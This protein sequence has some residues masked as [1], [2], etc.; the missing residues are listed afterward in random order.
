MRLYNKIRLDKTICKSFPFNSLS[1]KTHAM[2]SSPA[3]NF[4][5]ALD[6]FPLYSFRELDLNQLHHEQWIECMTQEEKDSSKT[7]SEPEK[8]SEPEHPE[9]DE[10]NNPAKYDPNRN[11]DGTFKEGHTAGWKKGQSGNPSGRP[12]NGEQHVGQVPDINRITDLLRFMASKPC[13]VAGYKKMTWSQAVAKKMY[14]FIVKEG[15]YQ[16]CNDLLDRVDG[17]VKQLHEVDAT[18]RTV[19]KFEV[20]KP[21]NKK[22]HEEN[23]ANGKLNGLTKA[24]DE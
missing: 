4:F 6:N 17:T 8:F 13:T 15:K 2:D 1:S 23:K 12:K 24:G 3:R 16:L 14:E 21:P 7:N 5:F 10:L 22:Q 19:L 11:E 20:A 18:T 9:F